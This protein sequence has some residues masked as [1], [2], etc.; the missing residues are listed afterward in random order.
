MNE[1][2]PPGKLIPVLDLADAHL[3]QEE[4]QQH[5]RRLEEPRHPATFTHDPDDE[6]EERDSERGGRANV[7]PDGVEEVPEAVDLGAVA[8]MW[9]GG[10]RERSRHDEDPAGDDE[11]E[12]RQAQPRR[13][14]GVDTASRVAPG[15]H[16]KRDG[17]REHE[18]SKQEMRPHHQRMQV[19]PDR[20]QAE[21][22]LR[23]RPRKT[24]AAIHVAPRARPGSSRERQSTRRG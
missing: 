13:S 8:R 2:E 16:G 20:Q 17:T 12:R 10:R 11:H 23:D 14:R 4:R 9:A 18:E 15:L 3:Q 22:R 19:E 6:E 24:P 5:R 7:P 1:H 21:R